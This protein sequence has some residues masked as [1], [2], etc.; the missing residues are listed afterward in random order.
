VIALQEKFEGVTAEVQPRRVDLQALDGEE[1]KLSD[2]LEA[3]EHFVFEDV[4]GTTREKEMAIRPGVF[5]R[6]TELDRAGNDRLLESAP[7]VLSHL[8]HLGFVH[9]ERFNLAQHPGPTPSKWLQSLNLI[10]LY[11]THLSREL[12]SVRIFRPW[13][14]SI[15]LAGEF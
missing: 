14:E 8:L 1:M 11:Q 10:K 5:H 6:R 2:E 13:E 12:D 4:N 9:A 7:A 3:A 15:L